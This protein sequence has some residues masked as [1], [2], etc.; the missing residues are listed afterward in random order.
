MTY[1]R[2]RIITAI[3]T[4]FLIPTSHC[5]AKIIRV[6]IN[7]TSP[8]LPVD[9]SQWP[10]AYTDLQSALAVANAFDQI[11]IAQGTYKP[12]LPAGRSA[13]FG[14]PAGVYIFGGFQGI[15]TEIKNT[16]GDPTLYP[17]ILSGDIGVAGNA[18]DN[19]YHVVTFNAGYVVAECH[20]ITIRDGYADAGSASVAQPDNTGGGALF[21]CQNTSGGSGTAMYNCIF[22]NNFAF[23]GGAIGSYGISSGQINYGATNCFFLNNQAIYGGAIFNT[24]SA[25]MFL[26]TFEG[27]LFYNNTAST[28]AASVFGNTESNGSS[29]RYLEM[30]YCLFYNEAAPIFT[31]DFGDAGSSSTN[32][33]YNI[34]WTSGTPYTSAYSDG[35]TPLVITNSDINGSF[36]LG[37]N[38]NADP[39]F[40]N[41]AA[42][43]FHVSPC[44]PVID[45]GGS[46]A[47]MSLDIGGSQR[48]QGAGVDL[49]PFET[50]QGT[51]AALP[52]VNT[53]VNAC[54]NSSA[55]GLA[56]EV[57]SGANLRWY[58]TATG[59]AGS[60][61]APTPSTAALGTTAY[62]VT[63]TPS[64][65]CESPRQELDVTVKSIPADPT[66]T[67][68]LPYCIDATAAPLSATGTDMQWYPTATGGGASTTA[69]TPST[70]AAGITPYYVTQTVGGCESQRTVI[71]VTVSSPSAEPT[72]DPVPQYCL[73]A[74]ASPLSATGANLR[75][76]ATATGSGS[77][78]TAPTPGTAA[79]GITPYYVTQTPTSSCE[80]NR[81]EIDVTVNPATAAPTVTPPSPY[82]IDAT[83]SPLSATGTDLHWY[84][85]ST[86]G[87]ASTTAP[88]P[89]TAA[90][91]I[92]PYYVTQ[93]INGCESQRTLIDV[94]VS[95]PAAAPTPNTVPQYCLNALASPLSANGANL[96]W[97]ISATGAGG[98]TTAPTPST[99]APGI[100]PY[101]VT[102]R[103][104]GYCESN[105]LEIDVTVNPAPQLSIDPVTS[106]P[107]PGGTVKLQANGAD[108]Y[109]WSPTTGLSDAAVS[110]PTATLQSD[111]AYTVTGTT[112]GCS[113]TA[114]VD[115]AV[116]TNC[117][118]TGPGSG[119]GPGSG[120]GSGSGL[121]SVY[122]IPSAFSP[123]GDGTNDL[124]RVK[125]GDTP[126]SF[127]M[128]IFNRYGGKIFE[129]TDVDT[130]WNGTIGGNLAPIGTYVYT[131]VITTSTGTIIRRQGALVLIR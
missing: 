75:W 14:V 111:I 69:P 64:G 48:F 122:S 82:C 85:T 33:T 127:N 65:S 72:P 95:S 89:S 63:Q 80:S 81:L 87:G 23:Y 109:L 130:G 49:G 98:S 118:P 28:G 76:Y 103:P 10:Q 121:G 74:A 45:Q 29:T 21:I 38:M 90:P 105:R 5:F 110:D 62:Y 99:A 6:N 86:G 108:S 59:G 96:Q 18:S 35:N 97:Y 22:T 113:A 77:S 104:A 70:A 9:G 41:A 46:Y 15:A 58:T 13:T 4:T 32:L 119:S 78:T 2:V 8:T 101:F 52:T 40:V 42:G 47:P 125:T 50:A 67:P 116:S 17:T 24:I 131:V 115:L 124:F 51:V 1:R 43:D 16:Q 44:S 56:S 53:P 123:N 20:G 3:L 107:C 39:L 117:S 84:A 88:T 25:T 114:Q 12:S 30:Q 60:T 92:T 68:V 128:T 19:C 91:G 79:P 120:P 7:N 26:Y 31:N 94:T 126:K 36:P 54:L 129:S 112:N 102:Q 100:T 27:D 83:A 73:N 37:S 34:I 71:N 11:W 93:T 61:T 57:T 55:P 106:T 66:Y